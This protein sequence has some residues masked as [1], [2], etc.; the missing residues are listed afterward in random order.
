MTSSEL[1]FSLHAIIE[2]TLDQS[3]LKKWYELISKDLKKEHDKVVI[4][5]ADGRPFSQKELEKFVADAIEKVN[6][7]TYIRQEE[8]MK[9]VQN[10]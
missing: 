5:A 1:K 2:T 7:G 8:L 4:Y 10:W 9:E 6:S 3:V